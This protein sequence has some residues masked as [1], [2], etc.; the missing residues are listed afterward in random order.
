MIATIFWPA[1][2]AISQDL[3]PRPTN[4]MGGADEALIGLILI[5]ALFIV[6]AAAIFGVLFLVRALLT[7]GKASRYSG[8]ILAPAMLGAGG[9]VCAGWE[10]ISPM[11]RW[12]KV[13]RFIDLRL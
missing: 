5:A 6:L 3:P 7:G 13:E 2:G 1:G 10:L 12:S 8:L 11:R 4:H 9:A